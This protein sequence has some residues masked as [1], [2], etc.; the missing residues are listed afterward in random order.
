MSGLG[1]DY[2]GLPGGGGFE[3]ILERRPSGLAQTLLG[4]D[5]GQTELGGGS[6]SP[7]LPPPLIHTAPG[8]PCP[9][10]AAE[11]GAPVFRSVSLAAS[12]GSGV[13]AF[14]KVLRATRA[15]EVIGGGGAGLELGLPVFPSAAG[16]RRGPERTGLPPPLPVPCGLL[17]DGRGAHRHLWVNEWRRKVVL[18]PTAPGP[19]SSPSSSPSSLSIRGS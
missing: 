15:W 19:S 13:M 8:Q 2:R 6:I 17:T 16:S 3:R 18:P 4:E 14:P 11:S 12:L 10:P 7:G 9:V 5:T 1:E